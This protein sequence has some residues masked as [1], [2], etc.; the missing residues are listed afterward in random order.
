VTIEEKIKEHNYSS[1]ET[2]RELVNLKVDEKVSQIKV[3][4][5]FVNL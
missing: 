1:E 2:L 3:D 5:N 4:T